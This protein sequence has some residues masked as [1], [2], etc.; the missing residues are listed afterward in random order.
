MQNRIKHPLAVRVAATVAAMAL[1]ALMVALSA[2]SA[3][4]AP[5]GEYVVFAECPTSNA[6]LAGCIAAKSESGEF[7]IGKQKV[8]LVHTQVLQGGF[9]EEASGAQHF[10]G[11]AKG[12]TL[13][14][15]PQKVPGGLSGLVNCT[16]ISN[17]EEREKCESIF[18]NKLTGVNATV[19][20]AGPASSIGLNEENLL[21][22]MG[23]ALSLPLKVKIENPLLGKECYVGSNAHPVVINLTTGTTAP[24]EPN[25]PIKGKLG[26]ITTRAEGRILVISNNSLV[27]NSFAAPEATGCGEAFSF[28]IDP[29]VDARL[30]LP[31]AAGH[32]SAI[33]NGTLEQTG[34]EAAREHE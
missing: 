34:V 22:E 6:E 21:A 15:T 9:T 30:G 12:N 13:P 28:L 3:M 27:N 26:S 23:T 19:E 11:A 33:L 14:P 24:P 7:T 25:K 31:S 29:I 5:K 18:E 8:P 20:L 10:V 4:A 16:E 2:S 17:K 32:N 1:T